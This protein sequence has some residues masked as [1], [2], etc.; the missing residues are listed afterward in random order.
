MILAHAA[1]AAPTLLSHLSDRWAYVMLGATSIITEEIAPILGGFAAHQHD[2]G[3]F[4]V[5][6]VCALG[7]WGG[8][9]ALYALGEWRGRWAVRRWPAFG[10]HLTRMLGAVRRRPWRTS[11]FVRFAFGA[12]VVLPIACGAA[13]VPFLSFLLGSAVSSVVWAAGF[14]ALG[15]A[16]GRTAVAV[17]GHVRRYEDAI[18]AASPSSRSAGGTTSSS[19][20][21]GWSATRPSRPWTGGSWAS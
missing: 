12:R 19:G 3:L 17:L 16:F 6:T 4:R 11:L 21:R 10:H 2:L 1:A 9:L 8:G 20:R 15:W 18:A 7:S 5:V 13:R 14:T